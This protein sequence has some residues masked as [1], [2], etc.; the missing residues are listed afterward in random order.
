MW[1]CPC[2]NLFFLLVHKSVIITSQK[3][4]VYLISGILGWFGKF[5]FQRN[6]IR[7]S[8]TSATPKS[9]NFVLELDF[10]IKANVF[11]ASK[12]S[13]KDIR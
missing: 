1:I 11:Y 13:G 3:F 8:A 4:Q 9:V 10:E 6:S 2:Y 5:L 7:L 12:H